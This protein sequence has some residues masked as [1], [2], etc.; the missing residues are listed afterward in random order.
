MWAPHSASA[1]SLHN[2][3]DESQTLTGWIS[4]GTFSL[5]HLK[6]LK[7]LENVLDKLDS[8]LN[9]QQWL[10]ISGHAPVQLH[11]IK[12]LESLLL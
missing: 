8:Q 12:T 10:G 9:T 1:Y 6:F 7:E 4:I 5:G 11:A 2:H 3:G